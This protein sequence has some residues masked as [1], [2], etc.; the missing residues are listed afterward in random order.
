MADTPVATV[1]FVCAR[2]KL[3]WRDRHY[4]EQYEWRGED[5]LRWRTR[6]TDKWTYRIGQFTTDHCPYAERRDRA[7][8]QEEI[9][10]F[11][12]RRIL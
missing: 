6:T 1:G 11:V 9:N 3:V 7:M 5:V 4:A 10:A 2:P 12:G 8:T